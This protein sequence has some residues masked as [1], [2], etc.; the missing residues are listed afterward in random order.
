MQLLRT[1][2]V[3]E[4]YEVSERELEF[5]FTDNI[6]VFDKIIPTQVPKKGE[7]LARTSAHWFELVDKELGI[8]THFLGLKEP[9]RMRVRRVEVL[10]VPDITPDSTSFLVPLEVIC[11][12]YVAGSLHDRL[13]CHT[14]SRAACALVGSTLPSFWS[15]FRKAWSSGLTSAPFSRAAA[16]GCSRRRRVGQALASMGRRPASA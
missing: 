14:R 7:T 8:P 13:R 2:K 1:G 10:Q 3:K 12:H 15:S 11:R 9:D 16:M 4:V 6:S 5:R